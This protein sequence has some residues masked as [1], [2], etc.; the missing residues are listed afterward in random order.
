MSCEAGPSSSLA[1]AFACARVVY[2]DG[3]RAR[4]TARAAG[5]AFPTTGESP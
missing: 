1:R 5:E 2:N 4:E 3:L